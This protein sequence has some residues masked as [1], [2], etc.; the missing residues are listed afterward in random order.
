MKARLMAYSL[1]C[2]GLLGLSSCGETDPGSSVALFK[3]V[4]VTAQASP[5]PYRVPV[6]SGNV[7]T[8]GVISGSLV[9]LDADATVEIASEPYPAIT[10]AQ[11][12]SLGA[13][14]VTY[15]K[16]LA[17]SPTIADTVPCFVGQILAPGDAV[18]ASIPLTTPTIKAKIAADAGINSCTPTQHTYYATIT[19]SGTEEGGTNSNITAVVPVVFSN[20]P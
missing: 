6:A 1:L 2:A 19:I 11:N 7:C 20:L 17:S 8:N 16:V 18:T 14:T 12:V 4:K 3:T 9:T 5:N 10:T 13:C 15:S